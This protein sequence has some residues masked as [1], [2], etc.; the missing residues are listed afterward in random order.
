MKPLRDEIK[1]LVAEGVLGS[2]NCPSQTYWSWPILH[3]DRL[4]EHL[5]DEAMIYNEVRW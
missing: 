5:K 2:E 1:Q 4:P 3:F